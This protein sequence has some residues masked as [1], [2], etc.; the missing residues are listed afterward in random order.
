MGVNEWVLREKGAEG[1]IFCLLS[2]PASCVSR[3]PCPI[4]LFIFRWNGALIKTRASRATHVPS[5]CSLCAGQV[6]HVPAHM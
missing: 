4:P 3:T 1:N 2:T 5:T 6:E